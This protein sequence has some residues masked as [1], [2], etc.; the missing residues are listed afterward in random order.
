[1]RRVALP[2]ALLLLLSG[3]GGSGAWGWYVIDPTTPSGWTNIKF[4]IS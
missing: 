3:C 2:L 4:L 1:M